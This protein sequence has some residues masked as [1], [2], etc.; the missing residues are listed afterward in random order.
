MAVDQGKPLEILR[1]ISSHLARPMQRHARLHVGRGSGLA[2]HAEVNVALTTLP[3]VVRVKLFVA[4]GNYNP[5]VHD[6][7][8]WMVDKILHSGIQGHHALQIISYKTI[9][10]IEGSE[11]RKARLF[12]TLQG[13]EGGALATCEVD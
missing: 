6:R 7:F 11:N 10:E 1:L 5:I 3:I 9:I 12:G 4:L 8:F 13:P 2:D